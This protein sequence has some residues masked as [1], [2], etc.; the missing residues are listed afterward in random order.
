MALWHA[1]YSSH[2]LFVVEL[3]AHYGANILHFRVLKLTNMSSHLKLESFLLRLQT[4]C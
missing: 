2:V 4:P 3:K 1:S